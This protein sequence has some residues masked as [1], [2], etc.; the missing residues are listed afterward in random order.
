M[1]GCIIQDV[2]PL[3][4]KRMT[5][6]FGTHQYS[7]TIVGSGQ[8]LVCLHGFSESGY[9]W[10]NIHIPGY[11]MIRI[12]HLGHGS[13]SKPL[14]ANLYTLSTMM[15]DLHYIIQAVAGESY[16]LMGYSMGARIALLYALTYGNEISH[17]ILESGSVGIRDLNKRQARL[18]AD[19]AL[20]S[21]IESHDSDW[22]AK[23]WQQVPIFQS[24]QA[25][26]VNTQQKIYARRAHNEPHALAATLRGSGQG[27][28]PYVG[29]AVANLSMPVL[30]I[31]GSLDEKYTEIGSTYFTK[32]HQI[33]DG[34]GHN[35]HV[36]DP[37]RFMELV[38][39]FLP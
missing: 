30:Y 19:D 21:K 24:Q 17:L 2:T 25:L 38:G 10:E 12:D 5:F 33:I 11:R 22:F 32:G 34:A 27:V 4:T 8:P 29:D 18:V 20:A 16:A 14:A 23:M 31:S 28:M 37:C 13:S 15:S 1:K 6:D 9:T 3:D 7:L 39:E 26:P 35:T 36:E